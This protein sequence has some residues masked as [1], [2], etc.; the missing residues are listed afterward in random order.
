MSCEKEESVLRNPLLP[1]SILAPEKGGGYGIADEADYA[2][3]SFAKGLGLARLV[4]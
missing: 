2:G 4:R 3:H 1:L